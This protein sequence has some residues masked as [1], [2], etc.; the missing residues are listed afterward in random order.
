M[1]FLHQCTY[2][3]FEFLSSFHLRTYIH[4]QA[5]RTLRKKKSEKKTETKKKGEWSLI[6]KYYKKKRKKWEN[7][8]M[9]SPLFTYG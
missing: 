4:K 3:Y 6:D 9:R 7:V 5:V 1:I 2:I 8:L